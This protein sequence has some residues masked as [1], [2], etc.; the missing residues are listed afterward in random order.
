MEEK[1]NGIRNQ[2]EGSGKQ[3]DNLEHVSE[4]V[5][6]RTSFSELNLIHKPF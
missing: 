2:I 5:N 4:N 1:G 6:M 3:N